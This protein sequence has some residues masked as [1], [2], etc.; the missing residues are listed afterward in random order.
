MLLFAVGAGSHL[1]KS[2]LGQHNNNAQAGQNGQVGHSRKFGSVSIMV[3]A[4]GTR[5]RGTR[6][7]NV[8]SRY[9]GNKG[10]GDHKGEEEGRAEK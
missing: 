6:T 7:T 8:C 9:K 3:A 1:P 2:L 5:D 10:E 4:L